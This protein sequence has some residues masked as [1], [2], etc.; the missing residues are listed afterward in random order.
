MGRIY[1]D[2]CRAAMAVRTQAELA[3]CLSFRGLLTNLLN[4]ACAC[5]EVI[6]FDQI[7]GRVLLSLAL[8]RVSCRQGLMSVRCGVFN[9]RDGAV[10]LRPNLRD[11]PA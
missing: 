8:M 7:I 6:Q 1:F 10:N 11:D 2:H 5:F 4:T 3:L 9:Q